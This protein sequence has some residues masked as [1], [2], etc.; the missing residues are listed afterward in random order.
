MNRLCLKSEGPS[1]KFHVIRD[2][3]L[4]MLYLCSGGIGGFKLYVLSLLLPVE[5]SNQEKSSRP[6]VDLCI[7]L[8]T[9]KSSGSLLLL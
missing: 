4:R 5:F 8:A 7:G 3:R 2:C 1:E 9:R 6:L